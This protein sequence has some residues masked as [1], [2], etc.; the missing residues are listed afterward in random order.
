MSNR[1]LKHLLGNWFSIGDKS[2][3]P[4]LGTFDIRQQLRTFL[5]VT[6]CWGVAASI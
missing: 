6:T 1:I 4:Y 3:P 2:A 5:V